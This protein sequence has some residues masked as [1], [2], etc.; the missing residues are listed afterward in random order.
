MS[1]SLNDLRFWLPEVGYQDGVHFLCSPW[2]HRSPSK[3]GCPGS[4]IDTRTLLFSCVGANKYE[5]PTGQ[6]WL[7]HLQ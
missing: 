3:S 4:M 1:E 5:A 7:Q 2:I 6:F